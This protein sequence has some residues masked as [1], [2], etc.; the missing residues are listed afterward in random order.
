M[1]RYRI[2]KAVGDG[3]Y[4]S[5]LQAINRMTNEMVAIKKMK[6][7]VYVWK[8][9]VSLPEITSLMKLN[10]SNIVKLYEVIKEKDTLYFVFEYLDKNVYQMTKDRKKYLPESQIRNVMFQIL[11]GLAHMHK[12][13]YFHRDLKP[14]NLLVAQ[15]NIIKL[16]D[17][18]LARLIRSKPPYTD[19]VSTR[20][21]RAPEVL[22]RS[23]SYNAPIDI[24]A[25]GCIMAELYT[26]R[27]LFPGA[28]EPDEINKI[29]AIL[30]TPTQKIWP[31]GM[32]LAAAMEFKFPQFPVTPLAKIVPNASKEALKLMLD[33]MAYDPMKRPTA[34]QCLQ[35]PYFQVGQSVQPGLGNLL[36]LG[37]DPSEVDRITAAVKQGETVHAASPKGENFATNGRQEEGKD[38]EEEVV[39]RKTDLRKCRFQPGTAFGP[40]V[41]ANGK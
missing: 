8:D 4:G 24:W 29:C 19:Y 13:G 5:V 28:S 17:F 15:D 23:R 33:M 12:K 1:D 35:S 20:W 41:N 30:G 34:T 10:H 2:I 7:H 14:E 37:V 11:Q 40:K 6:K 21:Y 18:G 25:L 27:P 38:D 22:L 26:F 36:G 31:E 32:K 39:V 3:T 9:C 16:A